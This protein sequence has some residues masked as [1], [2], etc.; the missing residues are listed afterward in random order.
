MTDRIKGTDSSPISGRSSRAVERVQ[1]VGTS[2]ATDKQSASA[3]DSVHITSS[4]RSMLALQQTIADLPEIDAGR[5]E[6]LRLAVERN[7]YSVDAGKIADRLLQ[8]EGD[9][10]AAGSKQSDQ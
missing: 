1:R 6:A 9:L 5:V 2:P 7:Q 10:G 4:A 8:L 3:A